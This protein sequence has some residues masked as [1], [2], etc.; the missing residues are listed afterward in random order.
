MKKIVTLLYILTIL[1]FVDLIA[2]LFWI[3][4]GW[5]TEANP[6]MDFFLSYSSLSFVAAKLGL[7]FSGIYILYHFRK[8]FKTIIL[9]VLLGLNL[10]Y[11]TLCAYHLLGMVFLLRTT[12]Y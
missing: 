9:N 6:M 8:R 12:I 4:G 1:T 11:I 2:T 7:S 10:I 5:A 3:Y